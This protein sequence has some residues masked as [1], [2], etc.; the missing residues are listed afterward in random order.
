MNKSEKSNDTKHPDIAELDA[1]RTGEAQ[2][3][4]GKHLKSCKQCQKHYNELLGLNSSLKE[5]K[6]DKKLSGI[7]KNNENILSFIKQRSD[8][9]KKSRSQKRYIPQ[10]VYAG[11]TVLAIFIV[12][13]ATSLFM[14]TPVKQKRSVPVYISKEAVMTK[15]LKSDFDQNG[16]V[17]IIDAFKM[18]HSLDSQVKLSLKWDIN[19]DGS[20]DKLDVN[21]IALKAVE[22]NGEGV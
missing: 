7:N 1:F 16:V 15:S 9:I 22:L 10:F 11:S 19:N 20:V 14:Q 6:F 5:I 3:G 17:D 21:I 8:K 13:S 4:T 18:F 12:V 2:V